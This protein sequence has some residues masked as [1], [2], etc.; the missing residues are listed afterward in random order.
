MIR[1]VRIWLKNLIKEFRVL[2]M[3]ILHFNTWFLHSMISQFVKN[4]WP[5]E[6]QIHINISKHC[7]FVQR[8]VSDDTPMMTHG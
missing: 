8:T 4:Y 2:L 5:K 6:M 3:T 1:N 7:F